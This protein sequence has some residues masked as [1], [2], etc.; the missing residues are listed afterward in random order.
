MG[1]PSEM[2]SILEHTSHRPW[3][4]PERPWAM[5]MSWE[6][7]AFLHWRVDADSI[8]RQLPEGLELDCFDGS[9]WLGV[10]P[11]LMNRVRG[12]WLPEIPPTNSFLELNVRTYVVCDGKPGVWFFSLDAASRLAVWGARTFF[13]L[14]YF[15]AEMKA[16]FE[17]RVEYRS[18]RTHQGEA[19]G[20]FE[21]D[22]EPTGEPFCSKTGTLEHW[23][24]E[25][26]CLY[27][28]DESGQLGRGDVQH[29]PWPLQPARVEI[30]KNTLGDL[31]GLKLKGEPESVLFA[32]RLDV[33]GWNLESCF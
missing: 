12:R 14:P 7:L 24:T 27:A 3:P 17:A 23:L 11:F 8:C 22:Y 32:R 25:R 28:A 18:R 16:S 15:N 21:A 29:E 6:H 5:H 10:V 13:H 26:Y 2:P 9:A 4:L 31:P 30:K 33:L 20:A 19:T 1:Y